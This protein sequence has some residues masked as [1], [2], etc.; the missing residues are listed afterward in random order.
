MIALPPLGALGE[1]DFAI[2]EPDPDGYAHRY[3]RG[4]LVVDLLAPDNAGGR[5]RARTSDSTRAVAVSGGTY[6]LQRSGDVAVSVDG[7][8]GAVARPDLAGALV[9]K[10]RAACVDRRRG[11]ARH[12]GD[13]AFLC[14][15]VADPLGL[16]QELG[17]RN[18]ARIAEVEPLH[19]GAHQAWLALPDEGRDAHA[20]FRLLSR[21]PA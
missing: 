9:I 15:L 11:P 2:G 13:L 4:R 17:E 5:A 19:D 1:L 16:Q 3:S 7:R 14:S 6:A 20:A 21:P 10:A 12:L 18:C 8:S